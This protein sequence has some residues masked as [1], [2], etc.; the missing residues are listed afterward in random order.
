MAAVVAASLTCLIVWLLPFAGVAVSEG[1]IRKPHAHAAVIDMFD[2]GD[3]FTY[4]LN[5][6]MI[7]GNEPAVV[8]NIEVAGLDP[9]VRFLGAMLGSPSRR[10][11]SQIIDHWPP[12]QPA[13]EVRPLSTPVT[14]SSEDR[15]GWELFIGLEITEPGRFLSD[16][17]LINYRVSG[18]TYRYVM[19]AR[20]MI[21]ATADGSTD[22]KCPMPDPS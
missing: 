14:P 21:C 8:T 22:T 5:T 6:L 7:Q 12:R 20:L 4:G 15:A 16:G 13:H 18:R 10:A 1:P 9:G 17:W 3:R 11:N 2:V 19:P